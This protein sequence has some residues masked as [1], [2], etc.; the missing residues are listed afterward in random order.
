MTETF[1][2]ACKELQVS[3]VW[4]ANFTRHITYKNAHVYVLDDLKQNKK[5]LKYYFLRP[6]PHRIC[7]ADVLPPIVFDEADTLPYCVW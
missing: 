5:K 6:S 2:V 3:L 4:S 1:S 7:K